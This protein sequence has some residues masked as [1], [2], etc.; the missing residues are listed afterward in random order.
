MKLEVIRTKR[1]CNIYAVTSASVE[2]IDHVEGDEIAIILPGSFKNYLWH[3]FVN[4]IFLN[5]PKYGWLSTDDFL[6]L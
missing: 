6:A 3:S 5:V 4:V 2:T 1:A